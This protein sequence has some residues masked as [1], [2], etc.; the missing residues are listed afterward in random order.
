M[1]RDTKRHLL[2][3][4]RENSFLWVAAH[5]DLLNYPHNKN[6]IVMM[7]MMITIIMLLNQQRGPGPS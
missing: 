6:V 7:V 4:D 1:G 5:A 3:H 2:D